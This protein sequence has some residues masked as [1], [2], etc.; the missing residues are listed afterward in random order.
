MTDGEQRAALA[1]VRSLGRAGHE[2]EVASPRRR[3]LAGASRYAAASHAVPDPLRAPA[4]FASAVESLVRQ[5]AVGMVIPI[6]DPSLFSLLA[7]RERL[8]PAVLPFPDLD[9]VRGVAD[10]AG[11]TRLCAEVEI[12]VPR[13]RVLRR[14]GEDLR[15]IEGF[16]IVVKPAR[17]V[18]ECGASRVKLGVTYAAN[19]PELQERL[20]AIPPEGHPVLLQQR[21]E[22]PGIGIFLLRW[23]GQVR[24]V[25]SHR[26]LR[27]KPPTGG[28]SVFRE[29]IP[30]DAA[31]VERSNH[32]LQRLGWQGVAMVEYKVDATTG[33]P[34]LMEI[35]GRFW[36]SL[37]LAIDAG[38]DF[39][40]LL[41]ELVARGDC[42]P[43][44]PYRAGVRSRWEW[45][46]AD[47]LLA[48][49]KAGGWRAGWQ[50]L[51]EV[52]RPDSMSR[53]EVLRRD[54]PGP[55]LRES[56]DWVRGR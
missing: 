44:P 29:S 43:P 34:Y 24:A 47:Y 41:A 27:E 8:A 15:G 5:R 37:Q 20:A 36:G 3:S 31:L 9:V 6:A 18:V 48:V 30:A 22:G 51:R 21:I 26:R 45:G 1:V 25:F 17:S 19:A 55:F 10:K 11:V 54:D 35:N 4:A 50:A 42:G 33:T 38:V 16:P 7:V 40:R 14:R 2:C 32:L 23:E 52:L 56:L 49:A 12:A 53:R 28:V 46:E 13:Q 39:P